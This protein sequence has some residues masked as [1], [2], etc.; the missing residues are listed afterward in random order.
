MSLFSDANIPMVTVLL[1]LLI[2]I[3]WSSVSC[4]CSMS[5][6][7]FSIFICMFLFVRQFVNAF[8]YCKARL[9]W[10]EI[11]IRGELVTKSVLGF[12]GGMDVGLYQ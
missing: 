10:E 11:S 5:L 9:G 2:A 8:L 7:S 4:F 6:F 3:M 1:I 12:H